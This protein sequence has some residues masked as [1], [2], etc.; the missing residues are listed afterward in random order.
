MSTAGL[1]SSIAHMFCVHALGSQ[2]D[3]WRRRYSAAPSTVGIK[4]RSSEGSAH[5]Q[6]SSKKLTRTS[7]FSP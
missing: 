4:S 7:S 6:I 1:G 5:V 3:E 2:S